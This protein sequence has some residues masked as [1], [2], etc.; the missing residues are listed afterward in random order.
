MTFHAEESTPIFELLHE[1]K[2]MAK[3]VAGAWGKPR[4]LL[5]PCVRLHLVRPGSQGPRLG[6][7]T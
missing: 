2:P 1:D 5:W 6:S 3:T 7:W 4:L